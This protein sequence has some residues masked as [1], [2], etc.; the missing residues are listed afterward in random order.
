MD[1]SNEVILSIALAFFVD[2][3]IVYIIY[4]MFRGQWTALEDRGINLRAAFDSLKMLA[5]K[6]QEHNEISKDMR[7][8]QIIH[9][10][11]LMSA[12]H[13]RLVKGTQEHMEA[14]AEREKIQ[15]TL[16]RIERLLT[17]PGR[18]ASGG[19]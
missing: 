12:A 16:D 9:H 2:I 8:E 14:R 10:K 7:N 6:A 4:R 3:V 19:I 1:L 17:G 13:E 11:E 15:A 18:E 5:E